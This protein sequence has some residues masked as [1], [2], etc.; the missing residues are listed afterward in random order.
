MT[1]TQKCLVLCALG[2][3]LYPATLVASTALAEQTT[4]LERLSDAVEHNNSGLR[5]MA[6]AQKENAVCLNAINAVMP[7]MG[8]K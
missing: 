7:P 3:G 2:L 1:E 5:A 6:Q 4:A 8:K